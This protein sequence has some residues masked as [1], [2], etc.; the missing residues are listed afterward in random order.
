MPATKTL[1]RLGAQLCLLC[2]VVQVQAQNIGTDE[3]R[4]AQEREAEL[5]RRLLTQPDAR[6]DGGASTASSGPL[7]ADERPC[8]ALGR[9]TLTGVP[10]TDAAHFGWLRETLDGPDGRDTPVGKCLGARGVAQLIDRAQQAL[11]ARGFVTSRVFAPAQDLSTGELQLQ[12]LPGR[13]R[14]IRFAPPVSERATAVNAVPARP[15]DI[16]NLRD[17]EQ[18]LENFQRVPTVQADIQIVPAD[19]PQDAPGLS[20][21]VIRWEQKQLLRVNLG[22]DDSGGHGTGKYQGQLT[23]SYDHGLT[24]N[25]LFYLTLQRDLGGGDGHGGYGTRGAT[26]HYSL[27]LGYWQLGFTASRS[28]YHQTV[29]DPLEDLVYSGQSASQELRLARL[30]HRDATSKTTLSLKAFARQSSNFIRDVEIED[31]HRRVGGWEAALGH[32]AYLGRATLDLSLTHRRGTG[33]FGALPAAE[34]A[35]GEGTSRLR[36]STFDASL[37]TPFDWAGRAWR[38]SGSLRVQ[39]HHTPL[40]PQDRFAIGGR[41]SVRGF[42]GETSLT[43]DSGWLVRNELS[44][45]LGDGGTDILPIEQCK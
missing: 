29:R 40:T 5:Q 38:Y 39:Q 4:R 35:L 12:V 36:L 19:G 1:V 13:I 18:A 31:Q 11:V 34:E 27:P 17:I 25:D 7:I 41:Y 20:D 24:L 14:A 3:A 42:D 9:I 21:L 2:T 45:A 37:Q 26:V 23:V 43:G 22:V 6:L 10:G 44:T 16:L 30:V 32:R 15:G 33:A 28:R 8:F